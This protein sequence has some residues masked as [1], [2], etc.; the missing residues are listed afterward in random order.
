MRRALWPLKGEL[1]LGPGSCITGREREVTRFVH[2]QAPRV[3]DNAPLFVFVVAADATAAPVRVSDVMDVPAAMSPHIV[4]RGPLEDAEK[5]FT[6]LVIELSAL[7]QDDVLPFVA[8]LNA[9]WRSLDFT[10]KRVALGDD[11][12]R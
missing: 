9:F 11:D 3:A 2:V 5:E 10:R 7:D 1:E 6:R 12:W 4:N 8:P